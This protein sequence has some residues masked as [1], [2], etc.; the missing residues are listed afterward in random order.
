MIFNINSTRG[1]T[2]SLLVLP[3]LT[4]FN[5]VHRSNLLINYWCKIYHDE[6]TPL[7]LYCLLPRWRPHILHKYDI[8]VVT[9][10][11]IKRW[12]KYQHRGQLFLV[13]AHYILANVPCTN[14]MVQLW[15]VMGCFHLPPSLRH[16]AWYYSGRNSGHSTRLELKSL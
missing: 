14:V 12:Y 3:K 4:S 5:H 6:M 15:V 7:V 2:G 16:G 11:Y 1:H 9:R 13:Q 10:E 8:I